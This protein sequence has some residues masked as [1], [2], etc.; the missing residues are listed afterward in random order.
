MNVADIFIGRFVGMNN[1]CKMICVLF[2]AV[3]I[4][5]LPFNAGNTES[6]VA[7]SAMSSERWAK[8]L[9]FKRYLRFTA[10]LCRGLVNYK[11]I[12]R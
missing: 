7:H 10:L 9:L 6:A 8:M 11:A 1:I 2:L 12:Q 4:V 3:I 5:L